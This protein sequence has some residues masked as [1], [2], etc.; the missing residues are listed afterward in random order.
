MT[1]VFTAASM[2][3]DGYIAGPGVSGFEYLFKWMDN[4]DV[5]VET[6]Q[7]ELTVHTTPT[8][9]AHFRD[10]RDQTGAIV[11]GRRGVRLHER[12]GRQPSARRAGGRPLAQRPGRLAARGRAV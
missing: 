10:M 11:V 9:A 3:L 4:G 1:K 7:P 2:S 5:A 6:T 8:S 12:L